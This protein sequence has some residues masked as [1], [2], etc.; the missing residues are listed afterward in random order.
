MCENNSTTTQIN[1]SLSGSLFFVRQSTSI[2]SQ[3]AEVASQNTLNHSSV[4]LP[5][6]IEDWASCASIT[7]RFNWESDP[8]QPFPFVP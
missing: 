3:K 4:K 5:G 2:H 1:F 7:P 8:S 6:E